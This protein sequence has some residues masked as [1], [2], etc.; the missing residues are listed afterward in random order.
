M[1]CPLRM[2]YAAIRGRDEIPVDCSPRCAWYVDG[3]CAFVVASS[4]PHLC[5]V[6]EG[7]GVLFDGSE[8]KECHGCGSRGWVR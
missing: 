1:F 4:K 3:R 8:T 6:C 7:K 5:P 2:I